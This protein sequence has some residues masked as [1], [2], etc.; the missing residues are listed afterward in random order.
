MKTKQEV[1]AYLAK[2]DARLE[3]MFDDITEREYAWT[4]AKLEEAAER[5][6][7]SLAGDRDA[8]VDWEHPERLDA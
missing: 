6:K 3:A 7:R 5:W 1:I 8:W 4:E 2:A